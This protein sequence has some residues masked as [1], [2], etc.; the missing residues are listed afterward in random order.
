M[1]DFTIKELEIIASS[2]ARTIGKMAVLNKSLDAILELASKIDSMI[3]NY[4]EH[5][6]K[7]TIQIHSGNVF[8]NKCKKCRK[9]V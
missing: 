1:N 8:A 9:L 4:C 3:N 6:E 2:V 5:E 7:E